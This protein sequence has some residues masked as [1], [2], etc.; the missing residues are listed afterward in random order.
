MRDCR[1]KQRG[2]KFHASVAT[3]DEPQRKKT[4]GSS[5]DQETRKEYYLVLALSGSIT[6][7]AETW[8]VDSGASKHMTGYRSALADL[9]EKK[10]SMQVE[11]GDDAAFYIKGVGSASFQLDS[12]TVL[13]VEEVLFVFGL[14]KNLLSVLV[15]KDKGFRV[16]L[17]MVK[18]SYGP[19][20]ET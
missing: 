6:T 18:P 8:L 7:S 12:G 4:R 5:S 3:E 10:F 15:L 1:A 16:T 11:L 9:K 14:K 13:H 2:S 19:R 20:M 17:W